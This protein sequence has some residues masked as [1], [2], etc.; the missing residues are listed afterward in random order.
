MQLSAPTFV[1]F[2]ISLV[3][4]VLGVLPLIGIALPIIGAHPTWLLL[5]GYVVLLVGVLFKGI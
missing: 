5:A 4:A 3:L 2:L 1:V